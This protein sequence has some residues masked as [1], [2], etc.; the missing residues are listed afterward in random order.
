[1][2]S[3]EVGM[4]TNLEPGSWVRRDCPPTPWGVGEGVE[5]CWPPNPGGI[6]G[7]VK[8]TLTVFVGR[9]EAE[10]M[11]RVGVVT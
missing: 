7:G 5:F 10:R 8:F 9:V 6:E 11:L 1:M 3:A 4:A 2:A